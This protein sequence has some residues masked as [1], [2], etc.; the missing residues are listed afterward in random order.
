MTEG[1]LPVFALHWRI[2]VYIHWWTGSFFI[3]IM[4]TR[5]FVPTFY[6]NRWWFMISGIPNC[7]SRSVKVEYI[8]YNVLDIYHLQSLP[9]SWPWERL[10]KAATHLTMCNRTLWRIDHVIIQSHNGDFNDKYI[11]SQLNAKETG[12][13]EFG[14]MLVQILPYESWRPVTSIQYYPIPVVVA[15]CLIKYLSTIH[16]WPSITKRPLP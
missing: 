2:H 14:T 6:L 8:E 13:G 16:R 4:V 7:Y 12:E 10:F 15:T 5:L 11:P 9:P 1:W 3:Q